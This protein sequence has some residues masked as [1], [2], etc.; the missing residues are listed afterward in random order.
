MV[1]L[2]TFQDSA[3]ALVELIPH[4]TPLHAA[5][6]PVPPA[7]DAT[8]DMVTY[9]YQLVGS[10]HYAFG[11]YLG[12]GI[13]DA[14]SDS[15]AQINTRAAVRPALEA[16]AQHFG[17]GIIND[18]DE[19]PS[20]TEGIAPVS[21]TLKSGDTTVGWI[22]FHNREDVPVEK[23][24]P[25]ASA[26]TAQAEPSAPSPTEPEIRPFTPPMMGSGTGDDKLRL[27]YDVEMTL[28]VEIGRAKLPVRQ[29]LDLTPGSIV[30]LDRVAGAPADLLVNGHLVARGEVVVVDEDYGLRVTE[31]ID[32]TEVFS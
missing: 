10:T 1:T 26:R 5:L 8:E 2:Q 12:Q 32:T 30:E 25:A 29:V 13:I 19:A 20:L 9:G 3:N 11:L 6:S 24:S 22:T 28:T 16:A 15:S 31:I 4:A 27:L 21:F 14:L 7:A 23:P 17:Q 18:L